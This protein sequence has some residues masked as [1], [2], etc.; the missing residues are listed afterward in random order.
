MDSR[1][2]ST[3]LTWVDW[4]DRFW[5]QGCFP[6]AR[7]VPLNLR[8]SVWKSTTQGSWGPPCTGTGHHRKFVKSRKDDPLGSFLDEP[9]WSQRTEHNKNDPHGDGAD[10]EPMAWS[11]ACLMKTQAEAWKSMYREEHAQTSFLHQRAESPESNNVSAMANTPR[12]QSLTSDSFGIK[13]GQFLGK[14]A[15]SRN[16]GNGV[17]QSDV[18]AN[19]ERFQWPRLALCRHLVQ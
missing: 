10:I 7:L 5:E 9:T 14:R 6:E 2:V 18:G 4:E 8:P 3:N 1:S 11:H 12:A 13:R 15:D 16:K 17:C 19:G